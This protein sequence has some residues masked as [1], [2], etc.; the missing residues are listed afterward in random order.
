MATNINWFVL[1]VPSS[2]AV[3]SESA[4]KKK[5]PDI[6]LS[7]EKGDEG[8]GERVELRN[9]FQINRIE[10]EEE[11]GE[12]K[13]DA[14]TDRG[15]KTNSNGT[16][17]K[18]HSPLVLKE[19]S[20]ELE[21]MV[22]RETESLEDIV[23]RVISERKI[24][25]LHIVSSADLQQTQISFSVPFDQ[26]EDLVLKLQNLGKSLFNLREPLLF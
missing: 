12:E 6:Q 10:E 14:E 11:E 19:E 25:N 23:K 16:E 20:L 18:I 26:V 15:T 21:D 4:E 7:E 1:W 22:N 9:K 17:E 2:Q 3:V 13:E 24:T 5:S 8:M